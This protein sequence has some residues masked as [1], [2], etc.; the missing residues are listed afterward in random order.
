MAASVRKTKLDF[1]VIEQTNGRIVGF[2]EKPSLTNMMSMG[3]YCM[4]PRV[5]DYIPA[6]VPFGFDDLIH[7][8]LARGLPA[9]TFA[10]DG[11]WLDIGRIEDFQIAQ[12]LAWDD[13]LP[14]FEVVAAA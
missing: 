7:T 1:G 10:H 12:E 11:L 6:G 13:Q 2:K 9:H 14:A 4:E 3:V 8:L 5:L